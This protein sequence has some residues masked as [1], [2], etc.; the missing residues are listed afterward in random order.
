[1]KLDRKRN[2]LVV[3][4]KS[5][6]LTST[7]RV[8]DINW[9]TDPPTA[10]I[11]VHTRIRYRHQGV[12]GTL[13]PKSNNSAEIQFKSPQAAITPGQGAVFYQGDEVLGGGWLALDT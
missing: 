12:A 6:L 2:R 13:F 10:P 4:S 8:V 5:D 3:G 11:T 9:I 1:V 7:C